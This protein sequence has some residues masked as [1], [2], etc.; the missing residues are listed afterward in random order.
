[1]DMIGDR[2][3]TAAVFTMVSGTMSVGRMHR[4]TIRQSAF[5][6]VEVIL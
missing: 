6:E 1:M 3:L 2:S 4:R 5:S